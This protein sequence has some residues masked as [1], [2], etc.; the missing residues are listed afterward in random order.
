MPR[1]WS[2]NKFLIFHSISIIKAMQAYFQ[3]LTGDPFLAQVSMNEGSP[4]LPK[5]SNQL[6]KPSKGD[7]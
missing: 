2:L 7:R 5:H 3:L 6:R 1:C 4:N